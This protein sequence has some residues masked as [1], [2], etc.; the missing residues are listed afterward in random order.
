MG[1]WAIR[2]DIETKGEMLPTP[3]PSERHTDADDSSVP[4]HLID[5]RMIFYACP[6]LHKAFDR[7]RRTGSHRVLPSREKAYEIRFRYVQLD[8]SPKP[9]TKHCARA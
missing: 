6:H 8:L 4:D 2:R 1:I 5:Q 3:N 7:Q 9:R